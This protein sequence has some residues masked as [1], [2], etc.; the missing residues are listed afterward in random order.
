MTAD[1]STAGGAR[2]HF[3]ILLYHRIRRAGEPVERFDVT[4]DAFRRQ[5]DRLAAC[6]RRPQTVSD[7][8][9]R[10]HAF[11]GGVAAVTF[12]DGTADFYHHAWPVL[13]ERGLP[14]TLYVTSALIGT[15][16]EGSEMLSWEQLE[17]LRAEGVEIGAHG[18]RH[19]PLDLVSIERAALELVNSKL[20]L[21]DRLQQAVTSFA[22]P[23]GYHTPAIK[24]L[25]PRVGYLSACGVKN[26]LSHPHDDRYALARLTIGQD[27]SSE[28]FESLLHGRGAPV[29]WDGERLRT[30]V[31]R[32]YRHT[33][34]RMT[35]TET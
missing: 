6:G 4:V 7:L 8:I 20:A 13:R 5:M 10:R 3:P 2:P 21:E 19:I 24:Q 23:Y 11:G 34:T 14:V 15:Q 30:R 16:H 31:W 1:S 26:R 32:A 35:R 27:T 33:R 22:Y 29:T 18:Y 28:R 17:E 12:D 25:L 9:R